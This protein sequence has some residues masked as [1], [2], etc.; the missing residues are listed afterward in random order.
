MQKALQTLVDKDQDNQVRLD[1]VKV[2]VAA[3]K[4]EY[5]RYLL[6]DKLNAQMGYTPRVAAE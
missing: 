4:K 6:L 3:G 1:A 5:E 2:L